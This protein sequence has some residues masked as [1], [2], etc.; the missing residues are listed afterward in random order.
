MYGD[1]Y[2][3]LRHLSSSPSRILLNYFLN[4]LFMAVLGL[5][6]CQ[7]FSLVAGSSPNEIRGYSLVVV[8]SVV[9]APGL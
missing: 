8:G 3:V 6:C 2:A 4:Y 1:D 5:C 9:S 7:G